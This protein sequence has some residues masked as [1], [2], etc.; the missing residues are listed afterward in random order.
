ME[1]GIHQAA[2]ERG[3]LGD[4]EDLTKKILTLLQ[5]DSL[6]CTM[7]FAGYEKVMK[8]YTWPIITS[9]FRNVYESAIVNRQLAIGNRQ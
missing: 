9:R 1:S 6:R 7:G 2:T 4:A 5:S 8:C 3:A